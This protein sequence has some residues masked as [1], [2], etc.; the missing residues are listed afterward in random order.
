[1]ELN[2]EQKAGLFDEALNDKEIRNKV[3]R[4]LSKKHPEVVVP[5]LAAEDLV[6]ERTAGIE[7]EFKEY[8]E[9]NEKR[10]A[11]SDLE[12]QRADIAAKHHFSAEDMKKVEEI[13][14]TKKIADY[15]SAAEFLSM[16]KQTATPAPSML[17]G[18]TMN[19]PDKA[20][21]WFKE[22]IKTARAEALAAINEI[23]QRRE[24]AA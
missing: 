19:L 1:M 21:A 7:K 10:V 6:N 12:K 20:G 22:P 4:T 18:K 23:R 5:E 2:Q 8:R 14:T 3:L 16:S 24:A 17:E 11:L 9:A 15:G 13:M